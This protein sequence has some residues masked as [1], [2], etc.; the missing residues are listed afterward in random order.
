MKGKKKETLEEL[1]LSL[2]LDQ[3]ATRNITKTQCIEKIKALYK[4][5]SL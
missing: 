2:I 5:H 1:T 4:R 3:W